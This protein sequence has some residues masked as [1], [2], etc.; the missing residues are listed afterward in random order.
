MMLILPD[1]PEEKTGYMILLNDCYYISI[2][3]CK[4]FF[5]NNFKQ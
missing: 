2:P 1:F 5:S 4:S 3:F